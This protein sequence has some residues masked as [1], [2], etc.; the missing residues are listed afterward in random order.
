ML[1]SSGADVVMLEQLAALLVRE[2]S[3]SR[4][5]ICGGPCVIVHGT[6]D[7]G[8]GGIGVSCGSRDGKEGQSRSCAMSGKRRLRHCFRR[9]WSTLKRSEL[10]ASLVPTAVGTQKQGCLCSGPASSTEFTDCCSFKDTT[11]VHYRCQV[12]HGHES[13]TSRAGALNYPSCH[14]HRLSSS[15]GTR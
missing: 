4:L 9:K 12:C 6:R 8:F 5:G 13:R 7:T 3:Q 11:V 14:S 15:G 10:S 2:S 1:R